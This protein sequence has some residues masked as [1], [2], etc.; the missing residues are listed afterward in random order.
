LLVIEAGMDYNNGNLTFNPRDGVVWTSSPI[1]GPHHR[2]PSENYNINEGNNVRVM[3]YKP[4]QFGV[5]NTIGVAL[6]GY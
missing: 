5:H 2:N 1:Y 6:G 3:F 4:S